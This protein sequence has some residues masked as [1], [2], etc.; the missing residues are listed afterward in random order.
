MQPAS[1]AYAC[2]QSDLEPENNFARDC[3]LDERVQFL[4]LDKFKIPTPLGNY[5]PDWAVVFEND[6]RCI[7]S[8]KP[9]PVWSKPT[10]A[11]MKT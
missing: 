4:L 3:A 1:D 11:W 8:P 7:L 9:N 5:N 10:A 6:E 2:V